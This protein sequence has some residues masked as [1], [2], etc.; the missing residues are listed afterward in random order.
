MPNNLIAYLSRE[1]KFIYPLLL[2]KWPLGC[3]IWKTW[4]GQQN[5]ENISW[6]WTFF[7]CFIVAFRL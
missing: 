4:G 5:Y 6:L 1:G 7:K 2:K 3:K